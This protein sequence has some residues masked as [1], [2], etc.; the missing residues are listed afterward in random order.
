[1]KLTGNHG[2]N[3]NMGYFFDTYAFFEIINGNPKYKIYAESEV[4]TTIFN[5]AELN[6]GLK[7][8]MSKELSDKYI[9]KYY[10]YAVDV[11]LEDIKNAMDCKTSHRKLS[12]PDAIG[13]TISKRF[14]IK[15][16]TGDRDFEGMENVEFVR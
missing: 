3:S 4:I 13:Y 6:Y 16:L 15:F 9:E 10:Q 2:M 11:T 12:I 14:N 1:M 7:K 5:L 8:K